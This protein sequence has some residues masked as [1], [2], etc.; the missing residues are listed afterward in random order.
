MKKEI[1][2]FIN[3]L[4]QK[5]LKL[6]S[7]R[8]Q[9]VATFANIEKHITVEELYDILKR[10]NPSIGHATVF[11]T[12]KLMC[13]AKI[14]RELDLGDRKTRYEHNYGQKHHD[15][16][17]CVECGKLIEVVDFEI[18]RLQQKLCKK[19]DFVPKEHKMQIFGSCR[20]CYSKTRK[21]KK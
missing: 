15:H 1:N 6:T 16:L 11:R 2:A 20:Q 10:K 3:F 4:R 5:G 7:Q 13:D 8:Q 21:H 9:I 14:A 12:L 18:E 19:F 17:I